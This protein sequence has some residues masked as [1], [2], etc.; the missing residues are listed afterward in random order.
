MDTK[1]AK[2]GDIELRKFSVEMAVEIG[3]SDFSITK[4]DEIFKYV[5]TGVL[6]KA[7]VAAKPAVVTKPAVVKK[8]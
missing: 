5:K 3:L 8:K 6:P 4:A 2:K 1:N 7:A